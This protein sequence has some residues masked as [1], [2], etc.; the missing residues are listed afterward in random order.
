MKKIRGDK[1][2]A[3]IIHIYMEILQVISLGSCLYFKQAKMSFF[4]F[5]FFYKIREQE[6]KNRSYLGERRS[7]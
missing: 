5:F 7:G 6:G 2:I 3:V 4:S 1:P